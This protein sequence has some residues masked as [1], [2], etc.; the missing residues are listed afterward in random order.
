LPEISIA[1]TSWRKKSSELSLSHL[2][3]SSFTNVLV[4][5]VLAL[6]RPI[7]FDTNSAFWIVAVFLGV[8]LVL[9]SYFYY[10]GKKMDRREG[11][12][13]LAVYIMFIL[14]NVYFSLFTE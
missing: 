11:I 13:L 5:G 3:S 12:I 9:F 14:V 2:L 4:F 1:I 7:I 8:I 10:S 6:L